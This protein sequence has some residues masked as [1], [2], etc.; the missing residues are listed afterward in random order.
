MKN[1]C[2][3]DTLECLL[4]VS[5]LSNKF[6]VVADTGASNSIIAYRTVTKLKLKS[7][8][9]PSKKAFITAGGKLSFPV[10]E[11]DVPV[12]IGGTVV[13]VSCMI[14]GK[15][16]F[17]MLL[18]LEVM[19]PLGAILDLGKDT[20]TFRDKS[21][22]DQI[23][24]P[25]SCEKGTKTLDNVRFASQHKVFMMKPLPEGSGPLQGQT[26]F[27]ELDHLD[28]A[29]Q[30][31][32]DSFRTDSGE[33]LTN[34]AKVRQKMNETVVKKEKRFPKDANINP[35]LTLQ[36]RHMVIDILLE[37]KDAFVAKTDILPCTDRVQHSIDTG[38]SLPI[39]T[40]PYRCSPAEEEIVQKEVDG[41]LKMGIIRES[42]SPWG[43]SPVLV[44][45]KTGEWRLCID[46]RPI[47][48]I[49]KRE[50]YPMPLVEDMLNAAGQ[51]KWF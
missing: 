28:K 44:T 1:G 17:S 34:K 27:P 3:G 7:L 2:S 37:C 30:D 46:Y 48:R 32:V 24:V 10:G 23:C 31:I 21:S 22:G 40:A 13:Q 41:M 26:F 11:I 8:I 20:F 6:F 15:A 9:R 43:S 5:I 49:T 12:S 29:A 19:K 16:S 45:K 18:G 38:D 50:A 47:N 25:L 39:Y 36:Q 33:K 42:R 14:V 35:D 4:P 51:S